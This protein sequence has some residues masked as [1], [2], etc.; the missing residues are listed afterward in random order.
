MRHICTAIFYPAHRFPSALGGWWEARLASADDLDTDA[1]VYFPDRRGPES[2]TSLH[3][4]D[5]KAQAELGYGDQCVASGLRLMDGSRSHPR[6]PAGF[7]A[8][9]ATGQIPRCHAHRHD[10][11]VTSYSVDA[12][13]FMS[14]WKCAASLRGPY[15]PS[16]PSAAPGSAKTTTPPRGCAVVTD[17]ASYQGSARR[18][19]RALSA[20]SGRQPLAFWLLWRPPGS[21]RPRIRGAL[22]RR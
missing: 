3:P 20:L 16:S 6:V 21:T 10:R 1:L 17:C 22:A 12:R 13:Y 8:T 15:P 14:A 7:L 2:I 11:E 9:S 5:P 4:G 19:Q 18:R